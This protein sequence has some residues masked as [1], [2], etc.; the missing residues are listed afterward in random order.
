MYTI[1]C[2][3]YTLFDLN[4]PEYIVSNPKCKLEVN[5]VGEASFTIYHDHPN[6]DKPKHLKSNFEI[7]DEIGVIFRGRMPTKA[8]DIYNGKAITLEGAMAFF[9]DSIV[10]PFKFP[11][12]FLENED[13]IQAHDYGN[14]IEF[15]LKWL[16]DNHNS[17]VQDFQK[18]KLGTVSISDPNNYI[19]RSSEKPENTWNTLKSKLFGSS[20]GGKVCIRYEWDGNYIDYVDKFT[21]TNTQKIEFGKNLL[22]I[23]SETD[24]AETYSVVIPYGATIEEETEAGEKLKKQTTLATVEDGKI[25]DDVYKI[26]LANG[27]HALYSQSAVDSYG[28]ICA[29]ISETTWEDVTDTNNLLNKATAYLTGTARLLSETI[30]VNAVDLHYTDKEIQSFRIYRN[31]QV[32]S[33]PHGLS[34]LYELTRLDIDLFN[35]QNTKI[36]VGAT[37]LGLTDTANKNQSAVIERLEAAEIQTQKNQSEVSNLSNELYRQATQIT[38]DC[39]RMILSALED[40]AKTSNLEEFKQTFESQLAIMA[41]EISLSFSKHAEQISNVNG[42]LQAVIENLT[43]HFLFSLDGLTIKAGE[44]LMQIRVDNDIIIFSKNGRQF[45]SWDGVNFRTGN[46]FIDVDEQATFGAFSWIPRKEADGTKSLVFLMT[47]G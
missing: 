31:V 16:I 42:D 10:P 47:G 32:V 12:D 35:P 22:D 2:D 1:K 15:F 41:Q 20:L 5:T 46:I 27:L 9:N 30:E 23:K 40:Y 19:T 26:T 3:N 4:I 43:K 13:F 24:A 11:E 18:F 39:S 21:L 6:Y 44:D 14:V 33:E 28:W 37:Q 34:E 36:T 29:P 38:S 17:Q 45:G 8:L 7:S 25:S